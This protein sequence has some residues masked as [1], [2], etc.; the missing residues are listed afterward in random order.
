MAFC[1]DGLAYMLH[2]ACTANEASVDDMR[3]EK[4]TAHCAFLY[5][6]EQQPGLALADWLTLDALFS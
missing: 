2:A 1:R 3:T 5:L 6:S 4:A